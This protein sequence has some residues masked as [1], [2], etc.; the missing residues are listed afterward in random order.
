MGP[1]G[2]ARSLAMTLPANREGLWQGRGEHRRGP[3]MVAFQPRRR[4]G[5]SGVNNSLAKK[6]STT[7]LAELDAQQLAPSSDAEPAHA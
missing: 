3:Q 4:N 1:H 7:V 5:R 6:R 2:R